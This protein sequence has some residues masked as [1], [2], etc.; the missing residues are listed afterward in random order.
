[1]FHKVQHFL[2]LELDYFYLRLDGLLKATRKVL[3]NS[4]TLRRIVHCVLAPRLK[5]L[6]DAFR[7]L[8]MEFCNLNA[9]RGYCC[10]KHK[11]D[12]QKHI[13][14]VLKLNQNGAKLNKIFPAVLP[15]KLIKLVNG[16]S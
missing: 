15:E 11:L 1:M 16:L 6:S 4:A 8:C 12:C 2:F 3:G 7:R 10:L 14:V 9:L 5:R 13:L